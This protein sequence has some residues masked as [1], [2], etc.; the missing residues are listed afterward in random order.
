MWITHSE[1]PLNPNELCHALAVEIGLPNFDAENI[2]SVG[3]II[4]CCQGLVM[5]DKEA[6]TVRLIH[7]IV[8]EYL[9]ARPELFCSAH[10]TIAETCLSY[11]NSEQIKALSASPDPDLE[12]SDL[13]NSDLEDSDPEDSDP[14]DSNLEDSDLED[15]DPK[16]SDPRDSNLEDSDLQD[17]NI[18]ST[19]FLEYSALYWGIHAKKDLSDCAKLLAL[20]L[21]NDFNC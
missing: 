8:Q 17:S 6:F 2:P 4:A 16:D 18:Q 10:S 15:S 9:L 7:F 1:R 5:V 3:L 19:A 11:L 13:E 14:E 20:K 21:F 12:D